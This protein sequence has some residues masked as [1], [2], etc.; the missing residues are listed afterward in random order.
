MP[1]SSRK[2]IAKDEQK[3]LDFLESNAKQSIDSIAKSCG[4]SRQKVWRIIKQLE[5]EKTIW[6]YSAIVDYN[7]RHVNH[8][9]ALIK[10][11][12]TP[13]TKKLTDSTMYTFWK[14]DLG[15]TYTQVYIST[16]II[17][18]QAYLIEHHFSQCLLSNYQTRLGDEEI[19]CTRFLL[20][21]QDLPLSPST[22]KRLC[23][24]VR[25]KEVL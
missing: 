19:M 17:S 1:K 8:Y 20:I 22:P 9:M 23:F 2:Q 4:F 3:V 25:G 13:V 24:T 6:G 18:R 7:K 5:E 10:R 14:S 21:W 11:S 16:Q 15:H 12:T